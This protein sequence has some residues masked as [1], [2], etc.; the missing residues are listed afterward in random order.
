[1]RY[2]C[3]FDFDFFSRETTTLRRQIQA[4]V[5]DDFAQK[6][7]VGVGAYRDDDGKPLVLN[8]VRK[9]EQMVLDAEMNHEYAPIIGVKSYVDRSLEF[10]YGKDSEAMNRIAAIQ[11]LSGTGALRV[12]F[13]FLDRFMEN[14][15]IYMPQPTWGNHIPIAQDSGLN[16]EFYKYY[17]A[18]K[19][20]MDFDGLM[21]DVRA[22]PNGSA[23]LLH[24]CAHNPTGIDPSEEEWIE[25]SALM[26]EKSHVPI[27]DSAYQG[28]ASGDAEKDAFAIRQFVKDGHNIALCQS[29]AK[30]FGL[31]GE[32]IGT[33]SIVCSDEDERDRVLSQMKIVVRPMYSNP[34]IYGARVVDAILSD[35]GLRNE[36]RSECKSM[37]DRIIRMREALVSELVKAGSTRDWSHVTRQIGMFC[38]SGLTPEQVDRMVQ[39]HHVYM[40]RNGRISMAGITSDNVG[41]IAQAMHDVSK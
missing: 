16:V 26:K 19:M 25:L 27:F 18:D 35:D 33:F 3:I 23:F 2:V 14:K 5:K 40:T 21:S 15:T 6:V 36:W 32:R 10:V 17:D 29:Y 31:Y 37:A 28:F 24:A 9:A 12:C 4:F 11:A 22:A 13:Q 38:F 1:M 20:W 7:N 30:N 34:P 41:Y 8:S 39:D